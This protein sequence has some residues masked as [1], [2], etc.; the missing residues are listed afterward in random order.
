MWIEMLDFHDKIST[1]TFLVIVKN[2]YVN[3]QVVLFAG[4]GITVHKHDWLSAD[5]SCKPV[6]TM[7]SNGLPIKVDFC[8]KL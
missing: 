6:I 1:C 5:I 3:S 8:E 7:L 4:G 2:R